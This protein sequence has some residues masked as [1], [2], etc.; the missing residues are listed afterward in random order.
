MHPARDLVD[1]SA[2]PL[3]LKEWRIELAGPSPTVTAVV[4]PRFTGELAFT[5]FSAATASGGP[6]QSGLAPEARSVKANE[7]CTMTLAVA[8]PDA[9]EPLLRSKLTFEKRSGDRQ[10]LVF[11]SDTP[12]ALPLLAPGGWALPLPPA[13]EGPRSSP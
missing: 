11:S 5:A 6:V 3:V 4:V 13:S 8:G 10:M 9:P 2:V 12:S 7:P 1:T